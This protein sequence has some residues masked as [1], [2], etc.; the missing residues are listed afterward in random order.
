MSNT[1]D[2]NDSPP[3]LPQLSPSSSFLAFPPDGSFPLDTSDT[4]HYADEMDP[5]GRWNA[6][7]VHSESPPSQ[8]PENN[9]QRIAIPPPIV[10]PPTPTKIPSP[11][12][13]PNSPYAV[14]VHQLP[15]I[16]P[17]TDVKSLVRKPSLQLPDI[18]NAERAPTRRRRRDKTEEDE[19][20]DEGILSA[21]EPS[22][23]RRRG[24]PV[25]MLVCM[26]SSERILK[27]KNDVSIRNRS[28]VINAKLVNEM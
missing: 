16:I 25:W 2:F 3:I 12:R 27:R 28:G 14:S 26:N 5:L 17:T 11:L 21:E 4:Y 23:K 1:L 24:R 15:P 10:I 9:Y 19:S 6:W 7:T 18:T 13:S 22:E 8:P 20:Y